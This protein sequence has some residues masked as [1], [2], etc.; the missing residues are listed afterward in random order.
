MDWIHLAQDKFQS[1]SYK[2]GDQHSGFIEGMEFVDHVSNY[3]HFKIE[4][5]AWS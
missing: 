3:Q 4:F 2:Q 1:S 5:V